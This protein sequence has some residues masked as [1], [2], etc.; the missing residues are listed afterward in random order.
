MQLIVM[1]PMALGA[2][3]TVLRLLQAVRVH[4]FRPV[5]PL[6]PHAARLPAPAQVHLCP[7][8]PPCPPRPVPA[9]PLAQVLLFPP[10][11]PLAPVPVPA[12]LPAPVSRLRPGLRRQSIILMLPITHP[13]ILTAHGV[14][15][16][17]DSM[18]IQELPVPQTIMV[19]HPIATL[20]AKVQMLP[21]LVGR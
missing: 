19:A 18:A 9:L 10:A 12:V 3:R 17:L 13:L 4:H 6:Q 15:M 11:P 5:F 1:L 7:H 16:L 2:V 8:R 20:R 21:P 14:S